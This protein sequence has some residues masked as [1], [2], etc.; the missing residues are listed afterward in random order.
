MFRTLLTFAAI[1]TGL[2]IAA[3]SFANENQ[4]SIEPSNLNHFYCSTWSRGARFDASGYDLQQTQR[5]AVTHCIRSGGDR[6][7]CSRNVSCT[8]SGGGGY[9]PPGGGSGSYF[10]WGQGQDGWGY[11]YEWTWNGQV[12]NGGMPVSN[13][14]C[15]SRSPSYYAWGRGRDG[16]TY[17]YQWTPKGH[18]MNQGQPVSNYYCQR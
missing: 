18:A 12:L 8:R 1:I 5:D 14:Y 4:I 16:Y 13:Y 9:P 11:C 6:L 2:L 7:E 17:C 10:D 3:P 15:E